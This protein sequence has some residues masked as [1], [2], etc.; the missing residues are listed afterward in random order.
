MTNSLI[1]ESSVVVLILL[2]AARPSGKLSV[3]N[4]TALDFKVQLSVTSL[5]IVGKFPSFLNLIILFV[6]Y[7]K[8]CLFRF[9]VI[10][11]IIYVNKMMFLYIF[12][13]LIT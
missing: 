3:C 5:E 1:T 10:I 4:Q 12:C 6:K 13:H 2:A 8:Q 7:R 9:Y 11:D